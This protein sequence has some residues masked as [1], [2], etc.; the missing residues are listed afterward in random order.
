MVQ[1]GDDVMTVV[2]DGARGDD[3]MIVVFDG[4]TG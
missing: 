2:L 4:A 3:V 1:Q